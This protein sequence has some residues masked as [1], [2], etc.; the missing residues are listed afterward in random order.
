MKALKRITVKL[1][2]PGNKTHKTVT[3]P[4]GKGRMFV[5]EGVSALNHFAEELEKNFPNED[6]AL[7]EVGRGEYNFVWIGKKAVDPADL[8]VGGMHLGEVAT[9]ELGQHP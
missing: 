7:R 3:L 9:V 1:F 8:L 2:A 4:A 5:D 6:Y